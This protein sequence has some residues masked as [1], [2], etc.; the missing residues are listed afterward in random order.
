MGPLRIPTILLLLLTL[1]RAITSFSYPDGSTCWECAGE[2]IGCIANNP[3]SMPPFLQ[4]D[5]FQCSTT[6]TACGGEKVPDGYDP[7]ERYRPCVSLNGCIHVCGIISHLGVLETKQWCCFKEGSEVRS[8]LFSVR[9]VVEFMKYIANLEG[10]D[11]VNEV[12]AV[13]YPCIL[14]QRTG[15]GAGPNSHSNSYS[16][17]ASYPR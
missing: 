6:K 3:N 10:H 11:H 7:S 12:G 15:H 17:P 13:V 2:D 1:P 8:L 9:G 16:N 14:L 5:G 4:G